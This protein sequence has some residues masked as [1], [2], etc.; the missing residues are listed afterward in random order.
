MVLMA[1]ITMIMMLIKK[2]NKLI[3][4][5]ILTFMD[6]WLLRLESKLDDFE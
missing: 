5:M 1:K 6:V 4:M 2:M 3:M